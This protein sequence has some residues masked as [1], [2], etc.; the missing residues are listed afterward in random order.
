LTLTGLPPDVL[1]AAGRQH[2]MAADI[3]AMTMAQV[4]GRGG[5]MVTMVQVGWARAQWRCRQVGGGQ[6]W[7][8]CQQTSPGGGPGGG[9][10][11]PRGML[12]SGLRFC[13]PVSA[14][15]PLP[16]L[17]VQLLL[18]DYQALA[19]AQCGLELL[20]GLAARGAALGGAAMPSN[21]LAATSLDG[22]RLEELGALQGAYRELL[23]AA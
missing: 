5:G 17:Q 21:R 11:R 8:R 1:L 6:Q 20:D 10:F 2:L 16:L 13:D 19:A 14:A 3:D 12:C 15:P 23:S 7:R 4:G 22:L 9:I 18:G